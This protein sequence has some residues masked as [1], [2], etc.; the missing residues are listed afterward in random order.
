MEFTVIPPPTCSL[1]GSFTRHIS[2]IFHVFLSFYVHPPDLNGISRAAHE[3]RLRGCSSP[4]MS[5]VS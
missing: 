4:G 2:A 5:S 3:I 1:P